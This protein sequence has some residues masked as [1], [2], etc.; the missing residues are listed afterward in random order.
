MTSRTSIISRSA[1]LSIAAIS[2]VVWP[3]AP[4]A[5]T[6]LSVMNSTLAGAANYESGV[7]PGPTPTDSHSASQ[8][9]DTGPVT[10]SVTADQ[11]ADARFA[12]GH[13]VSSGTIDFGYFA[14]TADAQAMVPRGML[15]TDGTGRE[16]E[17]FASSYADVTADSGASFFVAP[18]NPMLIGTLGTVVVPI[19]VHGTLSAT[20]S[21]DPVFPGGQLNGTAHVQWTM[22][23][24][25]VSG[26]APGMLFGA[27]DTPGDP[28]GD[29]PGLHTLRF[30]VVLG[31]PTAIVLH[32]ELHSSAGANSAIG[33]GGRVEGL[34]AFGSTFR[35]M[36][37]SQVLD[38]D[39]NPI[40][41]SV[42]PSDS[43]FDWTQA[44]PTPVPVPPLP[45]SLLTA[46][47]A[48]GALFARRRRRL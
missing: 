41:Y 22:S 32:Y 35:W 10:S 42:A 39:G 26:T 19:D 45:L 6:S 25:T 31:V 40:E 23:A 38:A 29:M 13:A 48:S 46:V 33:V 34:A 4:A 1:V 16:F 47:W 8:S 7:L 17:Y 24:G 43:G 12:V 37:I 11:G 15:D 9:G 28:I 27:V 14:A 2:L 3:F 36:G 44:A 18:A 21:P 20:L 30:D 5:A